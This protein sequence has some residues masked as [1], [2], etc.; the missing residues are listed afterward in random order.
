MLTIWPY[1]CCINTSGQPGGRWLAVEQM[2]QVTIDTRVREWRIRF[3]MHYQDP[4]GIDK[5]VVPKYVLLRS[6]YA[7][8]SVQ[9]P[10]GTWS[11][12]DECC[13]CLCETRIV[14]MVFAFQC[15]HRFCPVCIA[16]W[17]ASAAPNKPRTCPMCSASL[18]CAPR[19]HYEWDMTIVRDESCPF[20]IGVKCCYCNIK[21][22]TARTF[23][24]AL[25]HFAMQHASPKLCARLKMMLSQPR[26]VW[27]ISTF[28]EA[29]KKQ[30]IFAYDTAEADSEKTLLSEVCVK[31]DQ[32]MNR[33]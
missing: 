8:E 20:G 9:R 32:I 15:K 23:L 14:S 11:E 24:A 22:G 1:R 4:R 12:F 25:D 16:Q 18:L 29:C 27:A 33:C 3:L 2:D 19:V 31:R 21:S 7:S 5:P 30:L 28:R 13:I 10:D 17:L 6:R 26:D